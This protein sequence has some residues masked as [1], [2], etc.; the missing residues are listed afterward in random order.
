MKDTLVKSYPF[1]PWVPKPLGI[2]FMILMFIPILTIGGVYTANSTEMVGGKGIISEHITFI[3]FCTSVGMASFCPFLYQLVCIRREKMMMLTGMSIMFLLSYVCLHTES[4]FVLAICSVI[5]GFLRMVLMLA[6][7]FVLIKYAFGIEATSKLT[8]G[9]EP[10]TP[11]G[12]DRLDL[13]RSMAQPAVYFFFMLL[14]QAGTSLTAWL[15]FEYEWQYVYLFMMGTS[16]LSILII[17]ISMPYRGYRKES[18]V[19]INLRQFGN[20]AIFCL[21]GVCFSYVLVYGKTYDWFDHPNIRWMTI[22]GILS[23]AF[24]IYLDIYKENA[25]FRLG[26]FKFSNVLISVL[27]YFLLMFFN[28]SAMFVNVFASLGMKLDNWQNASLNNWTVLGY[29]I[30]MVL[31]MIMCKKGLHLKYVFAGGFFIGLAAAFMYFEV[32]TAG[33]FERM[34][35]PVIIRACGMMMLYAMITVYATQRLPFRYFSTW[36]CVMITVR[37]VIGP[38]SGAAAYTNALQ[39]GQQNYITRYAQE[40]SPDNF[41]VQSNYQRTY[42]GMKYQGKSEQEAQQMA[43]IATKGKVQV[44]AMLVTVKE[45]AGWTIWGC[46]ISMIVTLLLPYKKRDVTRDIYVYRT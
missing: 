23:A 43:S 8:P 27:L 45:M 19:P 12:W 13:D 2:I 16:L 35:Y 39:Y 17:F 46:L 41:E 31:S 36:I 14:G 20:V 4:I 9:M 34:K 40:F 42:M 18:I 1:Y 15:S 30:G 38:V 26:V 33:L 3:N 29:F 5:M 28:S 32:Q 11:E 24:F 6:H 10:P 22:I 44:Q 21:T 7:L 25:Y 37:M